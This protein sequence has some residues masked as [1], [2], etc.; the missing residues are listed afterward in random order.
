ME[1]IYKDVFD[2]QRR[3]LTREER[4]RALM[5]MDPEEIMHI[6]RSCPSPQGG[7]Y[8]ARF[9]ERVAFRN[10]IAPI[11]EDLE[12]VWQEGKKKRKEGLL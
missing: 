5:R 8:Y 3:H 2:F 9:A 6:A 12:R 7:A 11:A 1:F 4:E 10:L